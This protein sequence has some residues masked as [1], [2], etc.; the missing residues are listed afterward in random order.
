[1]WP[2]VE[3]ANTDALGHVRI[4]RDMIL[5][6]S[7]DK[8]F[9]RSPKGT[10]IRNSTGTKYEKQVTNL[11]S[12]NISG[13]LQRIKLGLSHD[14]RSMIRFVR[15]VVASVLRGY[16][17]GE[18]DDLFILGLDSLQT[19]EIVWYLEAGTNSDESRHGVAWNTTKFVYGHPSV[20]TLSGAVRDCLASSNGTLFIDDSIPKD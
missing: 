18:E 12:Q 6:G 17:F 19:A 10:V 16:L 13:D 7:K 1:M 2:A 5:V 20:C 15:E 11:Y 9:E 3:K 8:P 4:T 14:S